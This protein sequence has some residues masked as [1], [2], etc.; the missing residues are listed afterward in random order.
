LR[1]QKIDEQKVILLNRFGKKHLAEHN[2]HRKNFKSMN[3]ALL[4][5]LLLLLLSGF[6][7]YSNGQ[8]ILVPEQ[9]ENSAVT[10]SKMENSNYYVNQAQEAF[11][12]GMM[13]KAKYFLRHAWKTG[14]RND[15]YWLLRGDWHWAK[16]HK[17]RARRSWRRGYRRGC[18]DCHIRIMEKK[19]ARKER[20]FRRQH[21]RHSSDISNMR[22]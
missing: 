21:A 5:C 18:W 1:L 15:H 11:N 12:D 9:R 6:F 7:N 13:K 20:R 16:G 17:C 19:K 4:S 2:H 14:W 3:K 22:L 8:V 10:N